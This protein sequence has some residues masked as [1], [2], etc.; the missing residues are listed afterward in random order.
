MDFGAPMVATF[1]ANGIQ[2]IAGILVARL[3]GIYG[4]MFISF[5]LS[6]NRI[7]QALQLE[8]NAVMIMVN[9][10]SIKKFGAKDVFLAIFFWTI[11]LGFLSYWM[12]G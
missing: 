3:Q 5:L 9:L 12:G 4:D 2:N 10:L 6:R 7:C 11:G 1:K 8:K